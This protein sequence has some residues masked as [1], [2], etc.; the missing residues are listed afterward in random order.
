MCV[1]LCCLEASAL[2]AAVH[3][4][5]TGRSNKPQYHPRIDTF[6]RLH[7]IP[8]IPHRAQ[9]KSCS[10]HRSKTN[11]IHI[12]AQIVEKMPR[13]W[14][15]KNSHIMYGLCTK[16]TSKL[17]SFRV[18]SSRY[19]GL[20]FYSLVQQWLTCRFHS[21][22]RSVE[23]ILDEKFELFTWRAV[24]VKTYCICFKGVVIAV[25]VLWSF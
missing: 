20:D 8:T 25:N 1:R 7:S 16:R 14:R 24:V 19:H 4:M 15:E 9:W 2:S 13:L 6:P 3:V 12:T 23:K 22:F 21:V 11:F 18:V 17:N 5:W 10:I